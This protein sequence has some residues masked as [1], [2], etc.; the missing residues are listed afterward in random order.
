MGTGAKAALKHEAMAR[1]S[2]S[3]ACRMQ[4]A[5]AEAVHAPG[6]A[7]VLDG[8]AALVTLGSGAGTACPASAIIASMSQE[9][10]KMRREKLEVGSMAGHSNVC[11][12]ESSCRR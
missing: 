12:C 2:A 1:A 4:K 6:L 11:R 10:S 7:A 3:D 8:D 5:V 9:A